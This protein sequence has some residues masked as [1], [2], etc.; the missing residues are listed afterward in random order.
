LRIATVKVALGDNTVVKGR[1]VGT[2]VGGA[3]NLAALGES[4]NRL[5]V[6]L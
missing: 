3:V 1:I 5:K 6:R 4:G 2:S